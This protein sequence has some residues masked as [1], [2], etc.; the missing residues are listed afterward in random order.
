EILVAHRNDGDLGA[1]TEQGLGRGA[2]RAIAGLSRNGSIWASVGGQGGVCTKLAS[3]TQSIKCF[4]ARWL[5]EI[6]LGAGT[7]GAIQNCPLRIQVGGKCPLLQT[8]PD[9]VRKVS[10]VALHTS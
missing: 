2:N 3:E 4:S 6:L 9:T 5:G 8:T 7:C 1:S 10:Q